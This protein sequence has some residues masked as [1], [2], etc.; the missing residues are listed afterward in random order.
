MSVQYFTRRSA[1][2]NQNLATRTSDYIELSGTSTHIT[3]SHAIL[4]IQSVASSRLTCYFPVG[5]DSIFPGV[6]PA[7]SITPDSTKQTE[8]LSFST[9]QVHPRTECQ[10][11]MQAAAAQTQPDCSTSQATPEQAVAN[12]IM[13]EGAL[14]TR[15]RDYQVQFG[16]NPATG[17]PWFA[18]RSY[19]ENSYPALYGP[20]RKILHN[21][22]ALAPEFVLQFERFPHL[23]YTLMWPE[24]ANPFDINN[25]EVWQRFNQFRT[26]LQEWASMKGNAQQMDGCLKM[27]RN[28]P[29]ETKK[30]LALPH[31]FVL[32]QE[33]RS[34]VLSVP[35]PARHKP[36]ARI[37]KRRTRKKSSETV[38]DRI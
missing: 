15:D 12:R 35:A 16:W 26:F 29:E 4:A 8:N 30:A 19:S 18:V 13:L 14:V 7:A 20:N 34:R 22:G 37:R 21:V 11:D 27:F 28:R 10:K 1:G 6:D 17:E 38:R 33:M 23:G 32:D 24:F 3:V 5:E 36:S 9:T 2:L 25:N 31:G